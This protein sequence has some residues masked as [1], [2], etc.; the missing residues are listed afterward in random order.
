MKKLF[1]LF[2]LVALVPFSVGCSLWGGDDD[3][4]TYPPVLTAKVTV[5]AGGFSLL[6]AAPTT[7]A[8]YYVTVNGIMLPITDETGNVLTFSKVLEA[9]DTALKAELEAA[10]NVVKVEIFKADGTSA[11][12][13]YFVTQAGTVTT[14]TVSD[15]GVVQVTDGTTTKTPTVV[16]EENL[17]TITSVT[18]NNVAVSATQDVVVNNGNIDFLVTVSGSV[19]ATADAEYSVTVSGTAVTDEDFTIT[20]ANAGTTFTIS[21]PAAERVA[22]KAYTVKIKYIA[23]DGKLLD[24]TEFSFKMPNA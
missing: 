1:V 23:V 7:Y 8:G 10:G 5:P 2:L 19:N 4:I 9:A 15:T 12:A 20:Q 13:L 18:N 22:G 17:Y 11:G 24:A 16:D 6:G 3:A 14:V 21:I